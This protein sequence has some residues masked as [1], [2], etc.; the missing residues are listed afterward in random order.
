MEK[1]K[2]ECPKCQWEPDGNAYWTCHC[3]HTWNT[4]D[5]QGRCP[6][7][8]KIHQQTQCPACSQWSLHEDWYIDLRGWTLKW[9][10]F[11]KSKN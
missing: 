4:F 5:T 10:E 2:I 1:E 9:E 8:L 11:E 7:C 6:K 3:G